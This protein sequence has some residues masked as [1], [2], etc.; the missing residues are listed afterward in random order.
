M[1]FGF[2]Q[3]IPNDLPVTRKIAWDDYNRPIG[4]VKLYIPSRLF[5]SYVTT[6]YLKWWNDANCLRKKKKTDAS[7]TTNLCEVSSMPPGFSPKGKR[8]GDCS[9]RSRGTLY[10]PEIVIESS[11]SDGSPDS[12]SKKSSA[13]DNVVIQ[14]IKSANKYTGNVSPRKQV[15]TEG[16]NESKARIRSSVRRPISIHKNETQTTFNA[17]PEFACMDILDRIAG[18]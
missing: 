3:D 14:Q 17:T 10:R 5:E 9:K 4:N 11:E 1:Q 8:V 16:G 7:L 18:L 2:D 13:G 12:S 6:R 15:I